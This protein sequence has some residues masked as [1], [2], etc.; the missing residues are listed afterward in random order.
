MGG[1]ETRTEIRAL[2]A[3]AVVL[4]LVAAG[5]GGAY[6]ADRITSSLIANHTIQ[7]KDVRA[8]TLQPSN[9]D[10]NAFFKSA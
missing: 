9:V 1:S 4:G 10:R 6:A 2:V 5:I 3:V 7:A 8:R